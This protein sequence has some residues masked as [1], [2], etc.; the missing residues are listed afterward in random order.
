[1]FP[2][3]TFIINLRHRT[4]RKTHVLS[5]F[6]GRAEFSVKIVEAISHPTGA[7]GL[8]STIT[9]IIKLNCEIESQFIILCEDDHKFTEHYHP[10]TLLFNIRIAREL[11]INLVAGGVSWLRSTFSISSQLYWTESFTGLQFTIIHKSLFSRILESSFSEH[12]AADLKLSSLTTR[13]AFIYPFI[14]IQSDF[15]Y[16]D[17]TIRNN[18]PGKVIELFADSSQAINYMLRGEAYYI[19]A[20]KRFSDVENSA[21]SDL[22]LSYYIVDN[23]AESAMSSNSTIEKNI[24]VY[25]IQSKIEEATNNFQDLLKR[26][27]KMAEKS[28]DDVFIFSE[29]NQV[30]LF[31]ENTLT[32][33]RQILLADSIGVD[34]LIG[35]AI[36]FDHAVPIN[37]YLF[38]ISNFSSFDYLIIFRSLYS[39]IL[40]ELKT[41]DDF[42]LG[43]SQ[44]S[45]NKMGIWLNTKQSI[46]IN[47]E[48]TA[49]DRISAGA[50]IQNMRSCL[51]LRKIT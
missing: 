24:S 40:N 4:D 47:E 28:D 19:S 14:S 30:K 13:K 8:W 27:V 22:T 9:D 49:I 39:C 48:L 10:D 46:I 1:M 38:W 11:G 23:S 29:N 50:R 26:C 31:N 32:L 25:F 2:I 16:S 35:N 21:L 34:V 41:D 51:S 7:L 37:D 45:T 12:D 3:P 44:L 6:A 5:E 17:V 33:F 43:L 20:M 36:G 42:N 18:K 15:G